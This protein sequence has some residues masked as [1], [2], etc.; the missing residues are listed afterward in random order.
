MYLLNMILATTGTLL[1]PG[2]K[3]RNISEGPCKAVTCDL[4]KIKASA[5][6][7][8]LCEAEK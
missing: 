1:S 4:F 2:C 5:S 3:L 8:A 7:D 6:Y